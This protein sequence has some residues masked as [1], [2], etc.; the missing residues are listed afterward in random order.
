MLRFQKRRVED[1]IYDRLQFF[2]FALSVAQKTVRGVVSGSITSGSLR[3]LDFWEVEKASNK[4]ERLDKE[5][6]NTFQQV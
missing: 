6:T 4:G 2:C 5:I 3:V 1:R